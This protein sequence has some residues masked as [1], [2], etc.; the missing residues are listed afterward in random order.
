MPPTGGSLAFPLWLGFL[1]G[2]EHT[3]APEHRRLIARMEFG[4]KEV[5]DYSYLKDRVVASAEPGLVLI[6]SRTLSKECQ[7]E[8]V[9]KL[10]CRPD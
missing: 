3:I 6:G 8:E 10:V 4:P 7:V 9:G 5:V 2:S 1:P